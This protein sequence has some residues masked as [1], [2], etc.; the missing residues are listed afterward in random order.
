MFA[1]GQ[2]QLSMWHVWWHIGLRRY[3]TTQQQQ[4]QQQAPGL[5]AAAN[6]SSWLG[7]QL[8]TAQLDSLY[9]DPDAK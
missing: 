4:Q 2:A 1:H 3:G 8:S 6:S 5:H 7:C 9:M